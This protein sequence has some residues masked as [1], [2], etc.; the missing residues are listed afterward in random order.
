MFLSP[1]FRL[2][3]FIIIFFGLTAC[4]GGGSD[5][6]PTGATISGHAESGLLGNVVTTITDKNG[7]KLAESATDNSGRY[8][9]TA[10]FKSGELY[11][12]ESRGISDGKSVV[13]H[14][15]F[16]YSSDSVINS[17][18]L[19]ELKYQLVQSGKTL[20]ESERLIRDY[21]LI[22]EGEKLEEN[23]FEAFGFTSLRMS[24]LAK[25]YG[26]A[27]PT[28]SISKLKDD[29]LANA[30]L[31]ATEPKDYAYKKLVINGL[32]IQLSATSLKA[33]EQVTA[34]I[35]N[36]TT[37]NSNY[38]IEWSGVPA[39]AAGGDL[40]KTFTQA[41]PQDT[42]VNVAV[43]REENGSSILMDDVNEKVNFFT[44][45]TAQEIKLTGQDMSVAVSGE[46]NI[47]IPA[48][49]NINGGTITYSEIV[50]NSKDYVKAINLE[51]SGA[52][53]SKP[54]E[55]R[56]KYDPNKV[57]DPRRLIVKRTSDNGEEDVLQVKRID[58]V[59]HELVFETDHF[60]TFII[61]LDLTLFGKTTFSGK[62]SFDIWADHGGSPV[63]I[64]GIKVAQYS[65]YHYLVESLN[66]YCL[67]NKIDMGHCKIMQLHFSDKAIASGIERGYKIFF[68]RITSYNDTN[69]DVF[70]NDYYMW[71][72]LKKKLN[73][74]HYTGCSGFINN[75]GE[76]YDEIRNH[77]FNVSLNG[78]RSIN[79]FSYMELGL[80]ASRAHYNSE[81][82]GVISDV[83]KTASILSDLYNNLQGNSI[84]TDEYIIT[85]TF[86]EF[87]GNEIIGNVPLIG[88]AYSEAFNFSVDLVTGWLRYPKPDERVF[89]IVSD[90]DLDRFLF[91]L[92]NKFSKDSMDYVF[93]IG[94]VSPRLPPDYSV[95]QFGTFLI[96]GQVPDKVVSA[97]LAKNLFY[98]DIL[99]T[100]NKDNAN[101]YL[102]QL[103]VT[104]S[105]YSKIYFENFDAT[106]KLKNYVKGLSDRV[107]LKGA[108]TALQVLKYANI[109]TVNNLDS[110]RGAYI[111]KKRNAHLLKR[112]E[113]SVVNKST[114]IKAAPVTNSS[115]VALRIPVLDDFSVFL[116]QIKVNI[117]EPIYAFS[118]IKNISIDVH[119]SGIE[120]VPST[121]VAM[122]SFN[123]LT[124]SNHAFS[125]ANVDTSTFVLANG[126]YSKSLASIFPNLD[127]AQFQ[128]TFDIVTVNILINLNGVD[129]V[130]T[131]T[132]QFLSHLD[133]NNELISPALSVSKTLPDVP[134]VNTIPADINAS[135]FKV[136]WQRVNDTANQ[137]AADFYEI[138]LKAPSG[139]TSIINAG[140]SA[141][142]T[143]I[144]ATISYQ[145]GRLMDTSR[146]SLRVRAVNGVGNGGWSGWQTFYVDYP[147]IPTFVA[148][149]FSPAN[150][151]TNLSLQPTFSWSAI[152]TDGDVLEYRVELRELSTS[153]TFTLK[154]F[155]SGIA[156]ATTF[157]FVQAN[158]ANLLPNT[159]YQWRVLVKEAR[160]G[161]ANYGGA[162]PASSWINFTTGGFGPDLAITSI[163]SNGTILPNS[164]ASF[165]VT[166]TNRG[167]ATA[168]GQLVRA[169]YIKNGVQSTFVNGKE[170]VMKQA[171]KPGE[172]EVLGFN[173]KFENKI[174]M[175]GGV[176][177]DLIL[178][179]GSSQVLFDMPFYLE[180]DINNA[181]NA[182]AIDVNYVDQGL[183][184]FTDAYLV[185]R[186][187]YAQHSSLIKGVL[188]RTLSISFG[189]TDD[190]GISKIDLA[191]RL[192]STS[193]WVPLTTYNYP[194]GRT[195]A[196]ADYKWTIPNDQGLVTKTAQIRFRAFDASSGKASEFVT[197][198]FPIY[199]NLLSI[200]SAVLGSG[201]SYVVGDTVVVNY[202][203]VSPNGLRQIT[204]RLLNQRSNTY[205]DVNVVV[206]QNNQLPLKGSVSFLIP[207]DNN[208]ALTNGNINLSFYDAIS[209]KIDVSI[210]GVTIK[211]RFGLPAGFSLL[212][213]FP[214]TL[215]FSGSVPQN[216]TFAN[217]Y[218]TKI[219][220]VVVEGDVVHAVIG[221]SVN[222]L[223]SGT[224]YQKALTDFY[225][226]S[227]NMVTGRLS[228]LQTIALHKSFRSIPDL[229]V[230]NDN[231]FVLFS[232]GDPGPNLPP[233]GLRYAS[234]IGAT[235]SFIV[236]PEV[237]DFYAW[238]SDGS[239]QLVKPGDGGVYIRFVKN[240]LSS[241]NRLQSIKKIYPV[242]E[243]DKPI[244]NTF[245]G[246]NITMSDGLVMY[247]DGLDKIIYFDSLFQVANE[248]PITVNTNLVSI[249][250]RFESTLPTHVAAVKDTIVNRYFIV[251]SDGS[252]IEMILPSVHNS[253]MSADIRVMRD[254]ILVVYTIG[255]IGLSPKVCLATLALNG[256]FVNK[257]CF[258]VG[259]PYNADYFSR[260]SDINNQ[261]RVIIGVVGNTKIAISDL[262]VVDT[263][264][265]GLS[266]ADEKVIGTD[267]SMVDTDGDGLSDGA[268]TPDVANPVDTDGDGIIDP[269]DIA[270]N[271][272]CIPNPSDMTCDPD[273]DGLTNGTEATLKTDPYLADSDGDGLDDGVELILQ[274]DPLLMDTDGDGL[275]DGAEVG[276]VAN[277]TDTD[278]DGVIDLLDIANN[279][280]CI[281][282][283]TDATCDADGDGLTNGV[284][285]IL[286]TDPNLTDTDGDGLDDGAE[287]TLGT[288][289]VLADTDGD[290]LNDGQE[291]AL[292]TNPLLADTDGDT[293]S[294]GTEVNLGT[295]PL[296]MDTDGDN[297]SDGVEVTLGTDPLSKDSDLDG[298]NDDVEVSLGT[299]PILADTDGDGLNDGDEVTLT[300][301]SLLADTDGDGLLDGAE[302][303]SVANPTDTDGDGVID[304]L[305]IAN[306][307]VCQPNQTDPS[308]DPDGD[309]LTNGVEATLG[310]DPNLVDTDGD[311]LND[312]DEVTLTSNPLLADTDGDGFLDGAEVGSVANPTDTDGDGVIDLLDIA[313]NDVCQPN[314]TDLS[315][316]PDGDGLTNG[317]EATLGTDPNL[318][319]TDGDGLNDGA[320]VTLGSNPVLAD[321]D[322]DG[323]NDGQ[324]VALG[325]NPLLADTDG[326]TLSDGTEV[327]L[328]TNPLLMDSDGDNLS[329]GVEVTLGTDPLSKDSDLDG[330]NDDVE[331]SLGTNPIL[332]D[333]DGDGLNDGDEVTLTT[334]PLIADTD[335]DGLSDGAEVGVVGSPADSDG[336]GIIDALESV[337][338]DNDNDGT[339]DQNDPADSDPC[340]PVVANP[341]CT[342]VV[343]TDNDGMPDSWEQQYGFNINDPADAALDFDGDGS[344]NLQEYL[345]GT[346]PLNPADG[347]TAITAANAGLD[348]LVTTGSLA[349]LNGS[350]SVSGNGSP[351]TYLWSITSAPVGS[352]AV[353]SS[354]TVV[355]P[356]FSP[357]VDG[358]YTFSLVV[359]DGVAD[360]VADPITIT[361]SVQF[362]VDP[363]QSCIN[364]QLGI[365]SNF[366]P[367]AQ[368]SSSVT[369]LNCMDPSM[370]DLSA[371]AGLS[372]LQ[373]LELMSTQV[374]NLAPLSGLVTL[375]SLRITESLVADLTPL[376]GLTNL[377]TL[378]IYQSV[379]LGAGQASLTDITPLS[380]LVALQSLTL[381]DTQISNLTPLTGLVGLRSL[382]LT[383]NQISNI[384]PLSGLTGLLSLELHGNQLADLAP[385]GTLTA[386]QYL[387]LSSNQIVNLQSLSTLLNLTS[388]YLP[389]NQIVDIAPL[390]TLTGLTTLNLVGN[391]ITNI[392]PLTNLVSI[393]QLHLGHNQISDISSLSGMVML[394][395]L[396]LTNNAVSDLTPLSGV[397]TLMSLYVDQNQI[398]DFTPVAHVPMVAGLNTQVYP[399]SDGDGIP[400]YWETQYGLNLADPADALLDLDGDGAT[401]IQ[402]YQA[403]SNPTMLDTDGDTLNDG[404]E[405]SLGTNPILADSDG[406]GLADAA[407]VG[408]NFNL[409]LDGDG[410]GIIDALDSN[411]KDSDG[412]GVLDQ[413]DPANTDP[414]LPSSAS[415]A[416]PTG[417]GLDSDF[418][419][420]PDIWEVQYGL[421]PND[422]MD[423]WL[424]TDSDG[425]MN[426]Q[427]FRD[428]TDPTLSSS[429]KVI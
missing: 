383:R 108:E 322:G 247:S 202:D 39:D 196:S 377:Q 220:K 23:R 138:E 206:D 331:V 223:P 70:I 66:S 427:E 213:I 298:L 248:I 102:A 266:D 129:K 105:L 10:D 185:T 256:A 137:H 302:V 20:G 265:D 155:E 292:G 246:Y 2:F 394:D 82:L 218:E 290:G 13:L 410:D 86:V 59:N 50:T 337:L 197:Y 351:L 354:T 330:L 166:V 338:T 103:Y 184:V 344:T 112:I 379:L 65:P 158:R 64:N 177:Y 78:T 312:G 189:A 352:V 357:D 123:L 258:D 309:G 374:T 240:G 301:N 135:S 67:A 161:T 365:A 187:H 133:T 424:D 7:V 130:V 83:N 204:V 349:T 339:V 120:A 217:R 212:E 232:G 281:P 303:G 342:T 372:N 234:R 63:T 150:D 261:G 363:M 124:S 360:S 348:Q 254:S 415:Y 399:D 422:P 149:S 268:E 3:T 6:S 209:N 299:N 263:D 260:V 243:V 370:S 61:S 219:Y 420:M 152:D 317:V 277:P 375:Q 45:G 239:E 35:S 134:I 207:D 48:G 368:M 241:I 350:G 173:V 425:V 72:L 250:G 194:A 11:T 251:K 326:D 294:D 55:I 221:V 32:D 98:L 180:G 71:N 211:P 162:Y 114:L 289:P 264:G 417:G 228:P 68:D 237:I 52:I 305:D 153:A 401:N 84:R 49:A 139:A 110:I 409:P 1:L 391:Q 343:D 393:T 270:N 325:I 188:G 395:L 186:S 367:T 405:I 390:S 164:Y 27:I 275:S 353:L 416:C 412:D 95:D 36:I 43:Y 171:L 358:V 165:D 128:D 418:D 396:E 259:A 136:S 236:S 8:E 34:T 44:L 385:L 145:L 127:A 104:L 122:K 143:N 91:L 361:A 109:V 226:R 148:Q 178:A 175:V 269:L 106:G 355:S 159:T 151:A 74:P 414:C 190:F 170:L 274:A 14:S 54:L 227:V 208:F 235:S 140:N 94:P 362:V 428:G 267:P 402:E 58:Y 214:E 15:L 60:S 230:L 295:N 92:F 200:K 324:E 333:T 30:V 225:Y 222:Y 359:N 168:Q 262:V 403:K 423:A 253:Q 304:L 376:S 314:Q 5:P 156:N 283:P 56:V 291:V 400:D 16:N 132:Y 157:D 192:N 398:V 93:G 300:S 4:G 389:T 100:I 167:N 87:F 242:V 77:M 406:D 9:L 273:G 279:D 380:G 224:Y 79:V 97:S 371:I 89:P 216:T 115:Y 287:V 76:C 203:S 210:P 429:V 408:V 81:F 334:N 33:G 17:N 341:V 387:S 154:N 238:S 345:S 201:N 282:N 26:G 328:G 306:N 297:L 99:N 426:Y 278:G 12:L 24:E 366:V 280:I 193:I 88:A 257:K 141:S 271:D 142:S 313:N 315:C 346:D 215:S 307:D 183:P 41:E 319:D 388:L 73:F 332:A 198:A 386:L 347:G 116:D 172:S 285:A 318:V 107:L 101:Q 69:Y 288:N 284:E 310:T 252:L 411:V 57:S 117:P 378:S 160:T 53:F 182:K 40:S 249:P 111:L 96:D 126:K 144:N 308:C 323:L 147:N 229:T 272:I 195:S 407:E 121:S 336:D 419:G 181:N 62:T 382:N 276:N 244:I 392:V 90:Q 286:N 255:G 340:L 335:G 18:P 131:K 356:T 233:V 373:S 327:N 421:N 47:S 384:Q 51:P 245:S 205:H 125:Q 46:V 75:P 329:D 80:G 113:N 191:Y 163:A 29:I 199:T 296:L 176:A 179:V 38:R 42:Y 22:F 320:E 404:I 119:K 28:D 321:S 118:L 364:Q 397:A 19:T 293:L 174:K 231:V 25:L 413:T 316:D 146:Y 369:T 311:G 381:S 31:A 37:L 85:K 169:H 21:F